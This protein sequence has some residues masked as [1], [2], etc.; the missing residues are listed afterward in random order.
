MLSGTRSWVRPAPLRSQALAD[1]SQ[2][3]VCG[4]ICLVKICIGIL[5]EAK[6]FHQWSKWA[7]TFC[8]SSMMGRCWGHTLSHCPQA[9]QSPA[10]PWV[11]V[12][13]P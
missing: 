13:F 12:S 8:I 6:R 10:L 11:S 9:M 2:A 7:E 1:L 5:W 4:D 3:D